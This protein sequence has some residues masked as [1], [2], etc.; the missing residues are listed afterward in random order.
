MW[1]YMRSMFKPH[2]AQK[3]Y[4]V[5]ILFTFA[6]G[7]GHFEPLVPIA[8]AAARAG[9]IVAVAGRHAMLPTIQAAGFKA[10]PTGKLESSLPERIP[11][12]PVDME[13]ENRD[14]RDGFA[15]R[16]AR[17]RAADIL[18]LCA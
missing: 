14:L 3:G 9:H 6:G 1:I 4:N 17:S 7:N 2:S 18:A 5:R 13:R 15:D 10:F 16:L 12:R 8:R 11:L